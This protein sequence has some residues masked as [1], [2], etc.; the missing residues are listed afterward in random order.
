MISHKYKC[1]FVEVPKTGSSSIRKIIG[2]PLRPHAGIAEIR[3]HLQT[4]LALSRRKRGSKLVSALYF[5]LP[6]SLKKRRGEHIF[7]SYF[8]FGFVRNPWDRMVSLYLRKEGVQ[9][10]QSMSFDEFIAKATLSSVTCI[11]SLPYRS[12]KDWLSDSSGNL[13]VDYVGRFENLLNDWRIVADRTGAPRELSHERRNSVIERPHYTTFYSKHTQQI[14]NERFE[15]DIGA[16]GYC[17][18]D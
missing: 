5:C 7:N 18:G 6:D 8:K 16:F 12:Q 17:F 11:N 2:E 14:V 9:K 3:L 4:Y 13:L 15:Q 10:R 1:I